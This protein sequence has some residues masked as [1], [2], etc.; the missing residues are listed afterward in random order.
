MAEED[1]EPAQQQDRKKKTGE[2]EV[3]IVPDK[4]SEPRPVSTA[5]ESAQPEPG[6]T[7]TGSEQKKPEVQQG[8]STPVPAMAGPGP[9]EGPAGPTVNPQ[10][11]PLAHDLLHE[12][13][14]QTWE[15]TVEKSPLPVAVMFYS[16]TCVFCHQMEP[17]FRRYADE[18]R[19]KVIFARTDVMTSPWVIERYG[20]RST[21]TFK[22]FCSGKAV[23]EMIGAVYP[24]ILKRVIEEVLIHGKECAKGSTEIDYEISGYG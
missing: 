7:G 17:Y 5:P 24:A 2:Q 21:P 16:P 19:D 1:Q 10:V 13:T 9:V 3:G 15:K 6:T 4:K 20:V 18:Y 11:A 23:Q 14:D 12:A 8:G 22:F